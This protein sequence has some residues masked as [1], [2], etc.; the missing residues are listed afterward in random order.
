MN[1]RSKLEAYRPGTDGPWTASE[2]AHLSRRAAFGSPPEEV[3]RVLAAGPVEAARGFFA[4][5][6]PDASAVFA[7]RT[8]MRTGDLE[9]LQAAWIYRMLL[10]EDPAGEKLALFWHGHFA[11]SDRKVESASLMGRQ[12][13]LF[14]SRGRGPFGEL[15]AAVARD[16]AMLVWLDGNE[17]RRG[18]PN[19]NFARELMELFSLGIGNYTELDLQEAARAFTGWHVRRGEFW[20]NERS[21]DRGTKTVLGETGEFGGDDVVELCL[22][23]PACGQFIASK[24]FEYYVRPAPDAKLV[25][26]LGELYD[27]TAKNTGEFLVRLLSSR[28]FYEEASRRA[29]VAGP[30]DFA[31]G[32]LRTLGATANSAEIARAL[33][34][35]GQDLYRPPSVKGWKAGPSWLS[36]STLLARYRFAARFVGKGGKARY[37]TGPSF[38]SEVVNRFFPEGLEPAVRSALATATGADD[39]TIAADLVQLPESQF[40]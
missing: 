6:E 25:E 40:I 31:V 32:A 1:A 17:N 9:K 39:R 29:L 15:L 14:R 28:V 30:V 4:R 24:L 2:A 13:E 36:S 12:V 38:S 16:P 22:N 26:A 10:G 11:T 21:H 34:D 23:Q 33:A 27:E 7:Q 19:E 37:A 5:T 3:A 8:A 35:L 18:R 20:F